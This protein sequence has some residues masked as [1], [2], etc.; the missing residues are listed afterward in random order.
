M[1]AGY[2]FYQLKKSH[3]VRGSQAAKKVKSVF[4]GGVYVAKNSSRVVQC[5]RPAWLAKARNA[6]RISLKKKASPFC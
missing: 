2:M 1:S 3:R 5:R 4:C 6:V